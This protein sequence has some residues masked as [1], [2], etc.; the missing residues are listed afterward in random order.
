MAKIQNISS[1]RLGY[2]GLILEPGE[3]QEIPQDQA[4]AMT[5][6]NPERY[7]LLSR[8]STEP[9]ET[10]PVH[11]AETP[12]TGHKHKWKRDGTCRTKSCSETKP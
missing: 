1:D 8:P 12:P 6:S 7:R 3:V 10:P 5:A 2:D 11:G 4:E 9:L